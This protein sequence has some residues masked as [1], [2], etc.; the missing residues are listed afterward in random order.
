MWSGKT[1]KMLPSSPMVLEDFTFFNNLA[2]ADLTND[3]YPEVLVGTGGYFVHAT[4]ACGREPTGW[5]K[6]VGGWVTAT[7]AVGDVDGDSALDVVVGTRAGWL[8]AW[9]TSGRSD[10]V[11]S[12]PSFHH[13][14]RNTG[15]YSVPLDQGKLQSGVGPLRLDKDG[16]CVDPGDGTGKHGIEDLDASGGCNC[17]MHGS[18]DNGAWW[19]LLGLSSMCVLRRK[20]SS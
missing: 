12:W 3:G 15:N 9:K 19:L 8:F 11:V 16:K 2:V 18:R 1:G 20:R 14:N 13:D 6:F 10:G 4:D 17:E 5:P 7:T